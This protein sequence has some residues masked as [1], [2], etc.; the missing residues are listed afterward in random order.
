MAEAERVLLNRLL[1]QSATP[2]RDGSLGVLV[3]LS[4]RRA[5][6]RE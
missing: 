4:P 6:E 2:E 5:K 1:H 3:S